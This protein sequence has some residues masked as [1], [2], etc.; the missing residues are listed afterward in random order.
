MIDLRRE[1]KKPNFVLLSN[2]CQRLFVRKVL[3]LT[4]TCAATMY[5]RRDVLYKES[6]DLI[7]IIVLLPK[8]TKVT[9]KYVLRK[10]GH[11]WTLPTCK[12]KFTL[13]RFST[14]SKTQF[15]GNTPKSGEKWRLTTMINE[16]IEIP[17]FSSDLV[18][19]LNWIAHFWILQRRIRINVAS[20]N[21]TVSD[22]QSHLI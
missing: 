16:T 14:I 11:S 1:R 2:Y 7:S 18:S 3:R 8:C 21:W 22:V 20:L 5:L 13:T 12:C 10:D 19:R 6:R 4:A 17:N 9:K 15:V